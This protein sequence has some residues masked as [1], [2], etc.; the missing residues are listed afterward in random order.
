MPSAMPIES[1]AAKSTDVDAIVE[2]SETVANLSKEF[3]NGKTPDKQT[4][5]ALVIAAEQLAIAT[6]DPDENMYNFAA[7]VSPSDS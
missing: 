4:Q 1:A 7:Q 3:Q 2:L 6:R 5:E